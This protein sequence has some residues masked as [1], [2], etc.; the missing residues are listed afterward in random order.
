MR[1]RCIRA[2]GLHE[3]GD[4]VE[5]PD[6]AAFDTAHYEAAAPAVTVDTSAAEAV[7]SELAARLPG[8]TKEGA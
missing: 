8:A 2:F 6:A 7:V 3:P 4:E 5:V 1:L